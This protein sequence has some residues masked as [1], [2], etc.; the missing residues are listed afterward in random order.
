MM[1]QCKATF[2]KVGRL[3]VTVL[4]ITLVTSAFVSA[5]TGAPTKSPMPRTY[6]SNQPAVAGVNHVLKATYVSTCL[7]GCS[8]FAVAGG[9]AVP[10]DAL[11][12]INCPA[13]V[14]KTCTIV[15]DAWIELNN[16]TGAANPEA[17]GFYLDGNDADFLY[18]GGSG[19]P[20]GGQFDGLAHKSA[21][22]TGVTRGAH[23]VQTLTYSV[24]GAFASG[25]TAT[26][27][28]YVP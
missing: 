4:A 7:P 23:T 13:A 21:V 5:Q 3:A 25:W 1:H 22:A 12:T 6:T 17:L 19:T 2:A 18:N 26:Y 11:T 15:D 28:V 9:T 10:L 20:N 8:T 16:P 14:G 24:F 27:R